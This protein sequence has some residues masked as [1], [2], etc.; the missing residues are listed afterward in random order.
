MTI[1]WYDPDPALPW[2]L[3]APED[4]RPDRELPPGRQLILAD[5]QNYPPCSK[6]GQPATITDE[7][8]ADEFF[9]RHPTMAGRKFRQRCIE[10]ALLRA[11]LAPIA[12][13]APDQLDVMAWWRSSLPP[14]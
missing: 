1:R 9:D 3:P 11:E 10:R 4:D 12:D 7:M 13:L 2:L 5:M 6:C 8:I 14:Q